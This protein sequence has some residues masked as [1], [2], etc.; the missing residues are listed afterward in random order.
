MMA[1]NNDTETVSR[2]RTNEETACI[3]TDRLYGSNRSRDD[4][5]KDKAA[6]T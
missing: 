4:E 1:L 3:I 6:Y 2:E 5:T